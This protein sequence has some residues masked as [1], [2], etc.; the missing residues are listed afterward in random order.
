MYRTLLVPLDGSTFGEQALPLA[1][2]IARKAGGDLLLIHAL[3]PL[4]ALYSE[5]PMFVSPSAEDDLR[6]RVVSIHRT[7]LDR[8]ARRV[9]EAAPE[10]KV[11]AELME[12]DV[13]ASICDRA[14][15]EAD[16]IVMTTH[17]RGALA[18]FWLGS[19]ADEVIRHARVPTLLIR[20]KD[21]PVDLAEQPELKHILIPLDGTPLAEQIL[22][23]AR[24]LGKLFGADYTLVRVIRPVLTPSYPILEGA[25]FMAEAQALVDQT[26]AIQNQLRTEA[27]D[28]LEKI[29]KPMRAEGRTVLTRVDLHEQPAKAILEEAKAVDLVAL[30]THGRRGLS[31]VFVGSVA[32]KVIR[33]TAAVLVHRPKG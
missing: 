30:E 9:T 28:Y 4:A 21:T 10:V 12:G 3:P 13:A 6:Q 23:P 29:A 5:T 19:V 31:R 1:L 18:R 14:D 22:P 20:P 25:S 7:Y 26:E 16:L 2:N 33:G 17:G 15:K 27:Q 32:D 8:V 11:R 24:E